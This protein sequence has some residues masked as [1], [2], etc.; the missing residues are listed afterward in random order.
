MNS[1]VINLSFCCPWPR[2]DFEEDDDEYEY[3]YMNIW[4]NIIYIYE[5]CILIVFCYFLGFNRCKSTYLKVASSEMFGQ[6]DLHS[7]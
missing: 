4:I 6:I 1:F 7:T 3:E 2:K 5:I